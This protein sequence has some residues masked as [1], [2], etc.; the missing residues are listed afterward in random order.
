MGPPAGAEAFGRGTESAPA[1][2]VSKEP[3]HAYP[4]F[5]LP[6]S[7]S[8]AFY[9]IKTTGRQRTRQSERPV[10]SLSA[11]RQSL[12]EIKEAHWDV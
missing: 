2:C 8:G 6:L 11:R 5:T 1:G 4:A 10:E 3:G 12:M 9:W 7:D